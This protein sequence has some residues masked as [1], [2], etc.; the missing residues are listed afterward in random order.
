MVYNNLLYLLVVILIFSTNSIPAEPVVSLQYAFLVFLIKAFLYH[1]WTHFTYSGSRTN[2]ES[3]YF[4][5]EQKFSILAIVMFAI[6]VYV[7]DCKYY[8]SRIPLTDLVPSLVNLAG[9]VLFFTYLSIMWGSSRRSYSVIFGKPYTTWR[10]I[11]SNIKTNLPIVL[12]W[13][14]I[15]LFFD[16]VQLIPFLPL[17][18][19]M[20][21]Q[22]GELLLFVLFLLFLAI[23]FPSLVKKLWGCTSMPSGPLRRHI[24]SFFKKEKFSAD[25]MLWP[26]FEGRVLTAGI[27]GIS[28]RFRYLLITPAL[29]NT[30][31][32][33]ELDAVIAHEMGHVKKHHL[34][35]YLI[36]F[37]G[38]GVLLGLVANPLLYIL[39][40]SNFFY[41][42]IN[43]TNKDPNTILA[44]WGTLLLFFIMVIYFRY[45]FGFF[46]RNF[47]RQADLHVFKVL[48]NSNALI[49]SFEKIGRI[50]GTRDKPSWHH[51]GIGQRINFLMK[52]QQNPALIRMH[53]F[54]VYT[55]LFLFLVSM[56]GTGWFVKEL[57][58][59][60]LS[61]HAE[62]KFT[63]A[64]LEQR[65]RQ[66]PDNALWY[67]LKGD[68]KQEKMEDRESLMAYSK[69]LALAPSD[70]DIQNNFAWL[71]LTTEKKELRDPVKAMSLA[72]SA[73]DQKP[74]GY[75]LDTLATAHWANGSIDEA[76][77]FERQAL[78]AD[79]PNR[80]YYQE[81]MEKFMEMKWSEN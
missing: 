67:R 79:P 68:I 76:V 55:I 39:L 64:V 6:D 32:Q 9:L 11:L 5:A 40:N 38:F 45:I 51:F 44:F 1:R 27:M 61:S 22:W 81:Q 24:E 28:K 78:A 80:K 53:D 73:A 42:V 77:Y 74:E 16:L 14:F 15:T 2:T 30:L 54:K 47:E 7:L 49:R 17:K 29:I 62:I 48:G 43:I 65:I 13:I 60:L 21:S 37:L 4:A 8:L 12:P 52:C 31:D 46:M 69:A 36:F 34:Q 58:V 70:P 20:A 59:E 26:L 23:A 72:M 66:E 71:L 10:F 57:P 63:E 50:S 25:I 19:L 75:I 41:K 56:V 33:E 35:L 18:K 3:A